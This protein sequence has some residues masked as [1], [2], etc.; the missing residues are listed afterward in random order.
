MPL[1][2]R[3]TRIFLLVT[4]MSIA[5]IQ[6]DIFG[7]LG[8]I[9]YGLLIAYGVVFI[10]VNF[11][12]LHLLKHP[13]FYVACAYYLYFILVGIINKNFS[14]TG[15][16]L[17]QFF[18]LTIVAFSVRPID[19]IRKDFGIL[20]KYLTV[21]G[22]IVSISS[23]LICYIT[24][25][26]PGFVSILPETI[27]ANFIRFTGAFPSRA[28][29]VIGNANRSAGYLYICAL[30]ALYLIVTNKTRKWVIPAIVNICLAFYTTY[31]V[32]TSRTYML[33][34][35]ITLPGFFIAYF[36][37]KYRTK[38]FKQKLFYLIVG[39]VL[40]AILLFVFACIISAEARDYILNHIVRVSSLSDGT[41]RL[42]IYKTSLELWKEH[43]MLGYYYRKLHDLT[44]VTHAHNIFIEVL[45]SGGLPSFI[46]FCIFMIYT[47]YVAIRNVFT[48]NS[49]SKET[50]LL[51]CLLISYLVG[52]LLTG[53]TG[54]DINRMMYTTVILPSV[55]CSTHV[56]RHQLINDKRIK[57][58]K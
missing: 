3:D 2:L 45:A 18:I 17:I 49:I 9:V 4:I 29:G 57:S 20:S 6:I 1:F 16:A 13:I 38:I 58:G 54:G 47:V 15:P 48:K 51:I 43:K 53:M 28:T 21:M 27:K 33:C 46:F 26:L 44:G 7:V 39:I 12:N 36:L 34:L 37:S 25:Y 35:L 56:V 40:V 5:V 30:F 19:E 52:Y 55:M 22:L 10:A 42:G 8:L 32:F 31:I 11:K 23:L 24:Y 14:Y 50:R 41:G